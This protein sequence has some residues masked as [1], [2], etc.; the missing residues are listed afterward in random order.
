LRNQYK[1]HLSLIDLIELNEDSDSEI[2][3]ILA[4]EYPYCNKSDPNQLY[5][6]VSNL[7]PCL[8]D[9]GEFTGIRFGPGKLTG[10]IDATSLDCV[11]HQ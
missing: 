5:D 3:K 10:S 8:K 2:E 7:P 4:E 11:P 9:K 6:F 1:P